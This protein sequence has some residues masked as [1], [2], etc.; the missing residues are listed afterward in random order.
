MHKQK[1]VERF[2]FSIMGPAQIGE[3]RAPVGYVPDESAHFCPRCDQRWT[4]H[5][6][7]HTGAITYRRC[8]S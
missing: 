2:L 6:R 7:V 4:A 8:P 1:W 3:D 5:E